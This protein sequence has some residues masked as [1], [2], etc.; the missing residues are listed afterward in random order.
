M[1]TGPGAEAEGKGSAAL[2]RRLL[3]AGATP[4]EALG[5]LNAMLTLGDR[6]G[7]VAVD[8]VRLRLDTGTAVLFKWGAAPS[9]K[10]LAGKAA[11]L[12][13]GTLPPGL[14]VGSQREW[15]GRISLREGQLLMV[16]DGVD[17]ERIPRTLA[18]ARDAPPGE[19]ADRLL[20]G[21]P[22]DDATAAVIRLYPLT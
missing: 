3:T 8:L 11:K 22:R 20:E 12:G 18:A 21:Q 19:L 15:R 16:S 5:S 6:P 14:A 17:P 4:M 1:G 10:T 9:W 13:P 7:A 2:L